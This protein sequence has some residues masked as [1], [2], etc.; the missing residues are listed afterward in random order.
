M[1]ELKG[2]PNTD[3][4]QFQPAYLLLVTEKVA[5]NLSESL[6]V[7]V[8]DIG[9]HVSGADSGCPMLTVQSCLP[10]TRSLSGSWHE[11][12]RSTH[13]VQDAVQVLKAESMHD[14]MTP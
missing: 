3:S 14:S 2:W 4:S 11:Y 12:E 5:L 1:P 10:S 13:T 9:S 8:C 6:H 7:H